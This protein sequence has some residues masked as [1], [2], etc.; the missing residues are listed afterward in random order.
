MVVAATNLFDP[1][2]VPP[3]ERRDR[4]DAELSVVAQKLFVGQRRKQ[5]VQDPAVQVWVEGLKEEID[6]L[7]GCS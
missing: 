5:V 6:P 4:L 3:V 1:G 2:L 7:V